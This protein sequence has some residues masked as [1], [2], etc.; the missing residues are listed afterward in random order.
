VFDVAV[1]GGGPAGLAVATALARRGRSVVVL[2]REERVGPKAGETFGP[3]LLALLEQL[4]AAR[5]FAALGSVPFRGVRSAWGSAELSD[6]PSIQHPLGDGWH[7]D[8][9]KFEEWLQAVAERGGVSLR[10]G[11]GACVAMR[12]GDAFRVGELRAR[13]VVD[14]SG[15]GAGATAQL[16]PQRAW[17]SFDRQIALV[18]RV[19]S[20]A[21]DPE[22]LLEASEDGWW[23]AVPQP[24]GTLLVALLTDGDLA[25][26][27]E[28]RASRL[29][30]ALAKTHHVRR[31][32][33]G[34]EFSGPPAVVRA[35]TGFLVPDC[36]P[37]WRAVGDAAMGGDPLAGDGVER[38]LRSALEAAPSIERELD[39]APFTPAPSQAPRIE[40]YLTARAAYYAV[41]RRWPESLFWKRRRPIDHRRAEIWLAPEALLRSTGR[42]H[43]ESAMAPAEALLPRRAL[44]AALSSPGP[45]HKVLTTLKRAAPLDDRRLL[46][47]LQVLVESGLLDVA[48]T[49]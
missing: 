8:R 24:D 2:E 15:R 12:D 46:V 14:A 44:S 3:R 23:Y 22:L 34:T 33:D 10:R 28:E 11:A 25:G 5:D 42:D 48:P 26:P 21:S 31:L 18:G 4:D 17:L 36:G 49:T 6:R 35:D 13:Y 45:A 32:V 16:E 19:P 27:R 43:D 1:V 9:A 29:L 7:V 39:A 41:E 38:A 47:G 20:R 37:G 40:A 30:S